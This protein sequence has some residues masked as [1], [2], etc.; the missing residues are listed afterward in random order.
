MNERRCKLKIILEV[1]AKYRKN[2]QQMLFDFIKL[3]PK[4][5]GILNNITY[6]VINDYKIEKQIPEWKQDGLN[7]RKFIAKYMDGAKFKTSQ[8][9]RDSSYH[10]VSYGNSCDVRIVRFKTNLVFTSGLDDEL[11]VSICDQDCG[12]KIESFFKKLKMLR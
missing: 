1:D 6:S 11:N 9:Q 4:N 10:V 2:H 7:V 12:L 8:Y 3:H 5:T